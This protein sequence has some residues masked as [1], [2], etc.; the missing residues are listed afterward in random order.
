MCKKQD[1]K[2]IKQVNRLFALDVMVMGLVLSILGWGSLEIVSNNEALAS[3]SEKHVAL[4]KVATTIN[5]IGRT[6]VRLEV[7]QAAYQAG[8]KKDIIHIKQAINAINFRMEKQY[9]N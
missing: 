9:E 7:S 3:L 5:T 2:V 6:V 1:T 8:S 4:D